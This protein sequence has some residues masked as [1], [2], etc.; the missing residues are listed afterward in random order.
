MGL[1]EKI[2][3]A[4]VGNPYSAVAVIAA[5]GFYAMSRSTATGDIAVTM[6][7]MLIFLLLITMAVEF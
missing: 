1:P 3:N 4:L 6:V 2:L 5:T 7:L